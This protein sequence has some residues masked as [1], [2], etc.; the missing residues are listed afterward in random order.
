MQNRIGY[1]VTASGITAV[2]DGE[3]YAITSDNASYHE[4]L[5]AIIA[6][7]DPARIADL[8]RTANAIKRYTKGAVEIAA[9]GSALFYKGEEIKN[10]IVDRILQF[11][12]GNLPVEPLIAFLE[13]LL[14]NPSKHS[15]DALYTFLENGNMPITEDGCF[16]GYKGVTQEL[17]DCHTSTIDNSPGRKPEM[18]RRLVN[19]NP[20]EDCSYGFH[21][22]TLNYGSTFGPRCVI[23]KV[24]PADVVSVPSS[25]LSWKLRTCK[26]EVLCEYQGALNDTFARSDRPYGDACENEY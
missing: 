25:N 24:D 10:V 16:L 22:G 2:I 7:E 6:K 3:Q 26:Y 18:P 19:D 4:V 8:F 12:T 5:N 14:Q 1:I 15:V 20:R 11:M 17:K 9:D 21:V 23:V 13:R